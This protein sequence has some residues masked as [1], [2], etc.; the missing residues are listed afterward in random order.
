MKNEKRKENHYRLKEVKKMDT[1]NI[2]NQ[3]L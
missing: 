3:Q 1:D 2:P